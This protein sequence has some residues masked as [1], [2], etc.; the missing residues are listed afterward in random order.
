MLL[1]LAVIASATLIS[2]CDSTS[3]INDPEVKKAMQERSEAIQQQDAK[4]TA[5]NKKTGGKNAAVIK[6]MKGRMGVE[7]TPESK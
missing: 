4:N 5:A 7:T 3:D 2:G 6:S 1:S